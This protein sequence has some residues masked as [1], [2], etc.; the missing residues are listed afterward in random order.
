MALMV[1]KIGMGYLCL[2]NITAFVTMAADKRKAVK[3][4]WRIPERV[5]FGLAIL[6]GSI[7]AIAGMY[8]FHHKTRHRS[9]TIGLPAIL[10]VQLSAAGY[11]FWSIG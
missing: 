6:G 7:G 5:L 9:F 1:L 3:G 4:K 10:L 2:I 11:L 8:T